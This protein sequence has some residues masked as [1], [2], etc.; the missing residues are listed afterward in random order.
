M[1][2]KQTNGMGTIVARKDGWYQAAVYVYTP[3][4]ERTRKYVYGKTW[5]EVN[6]KRIELLENNRKAIPSATSSTKLAD[7]FDY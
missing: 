5:K 4:G 3:T 1:A 7:Y 6:D 2:R